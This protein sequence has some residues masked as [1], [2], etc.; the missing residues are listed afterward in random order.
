MNLFYF[1][2]KRKSTFNKWLVKF[3]Q[4]VC[5]PTP[6][7]IYNE[8]DPITADLPF[9]LQSITQEQLTSR[10]TKQYQGFV[11]SSRTSSLYTYMVTFTTS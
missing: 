5:I 7:N 10:F 4:R 11:G 1:Y 3:A 2:F 8:H 6:D 9:I